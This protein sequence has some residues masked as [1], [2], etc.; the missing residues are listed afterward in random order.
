MGLAYPESRALGSP[1]LSC[2]VCLVCQ[3]GEAAVG[4]QG[5]GVSRT[6]K[7]D[8]PAL[9]GSRV[10]G[11]AASWCLF[12][13]STPGTSPPGTPACQLCGQATLALGL[14]LLCPSS[15]QTEAQTD[16]AD[17]VVSDPFH[18]ALS[19]GFKGL[20]RGRPCCA[21]TC[22]GIIERLMM[23]FRVWLTGCP[24]EWGALGTMS[25][26]FSRA[27]GLSEEASF[28]PDK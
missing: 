18:L 28:H 25:W 21:P 13:P 27:A 20:L 4:G 2:L 11:R 15:G 7:P 22:N 17:G 6:E 8:G 23:G 26:A 9:G 12:P 1:E 24:I 14:S 3:P 5:G 10:R 16:E 19:L